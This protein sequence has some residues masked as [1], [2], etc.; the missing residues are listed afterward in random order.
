MRSIIVAISIAI[1]F[2][3]ACANAAD[4]LKIIKDRG[5]LIVGVKADYQPFGYRDAS[6][7]L[8][9]VEPDMAKMLAQKLNV[10]LKLVPVTAAN[11]FELLQSGAIDV[12]MATICDL[13]N[14][15]MLAGMIEPHYHAAA[16]NVLTKRNSGLN[17]WQDVKDAKI[18][19]MKGS[20][21]NDLP[22]KYGASILEFSDIPAALAALKQGECAGFA[23]EDGY[24]QSRFMSEPEVWKDYAMPFSPEDEQLWS[25]AVRVDD[26][27]GPLGK[28][29][30][31]DLMEWHAEGVLIQNESKWKVN[32][33]EFMDRM[34][35][36]FKHN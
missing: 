33:R 20:H 6:G 4:G 18:C 14:R 31:E 22:I 35:V 16:T 36:Q 12:A 27:D 21:Y 8:V 15:R 1:G 9:G 26:L 25:V 19:G 29:I 5:E 23:Y 2:G 3:V 32:H 13:P 24:I 10:K 11:R 30:S 17:T 34:A 7:S 28:A